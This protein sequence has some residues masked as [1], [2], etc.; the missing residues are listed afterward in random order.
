MY[1]T[2]LLEY[3]RTSMHV[4]LMKALDGGSKA[5]MWWVTLTTRHTDTCIYNCLRMRE[6]LCVFVFLVL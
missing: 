5:K 1:F 3:L 6:A 2:N 4:V